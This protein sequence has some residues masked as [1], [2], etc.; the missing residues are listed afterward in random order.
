MCTHAHT[1]PPT[2]THTETRGRAMPVA[3]VVPERDEAAGR[4]A[5]VRPSTHAETQGMSSGVGLARSRGGVRFKAHK[6]VVGEEGRAFPI[7]PEC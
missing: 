2:H 4:H 7:H 1:H 5:S 3:R 6:H